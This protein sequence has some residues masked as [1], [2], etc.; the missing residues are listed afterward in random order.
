MTSLRWLGHASALIELQ[1][2]RILTDPVMRGRVAHLTRR[3]PQPAD[4]GPVDVVLISH[5]HG[6][7]LDVP[8]LMALPPAT[9]VV[10]PLGAGDRLRKRGFEAVIE[11]SEG[12]STEVSGV[13]LTATPAQHPARRTPFSRLVPSLG[14]VM[15]AGMRVYF[16]GDTD[17]YESM[18]ELAPIDVAL[19]P[20]WGWGPSIGP[21]HLNPRTAVDALRLLHP[22]IAVP[23]HWGTFFPVYRRGPVPAHPPLE[24][25]RL[26][27]ELMPDVQVCVLQPGETLPLD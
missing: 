16:A 7:H 12:E 23:I 4:V 9:P 2:A 22:R 10:M 13:R 11:L 20:V 26:A 21:G 14:F 1:G 27:A 17:L 15:D 19:L 18:S 3:V 24:F 25:A 6:D 8:S 5:V